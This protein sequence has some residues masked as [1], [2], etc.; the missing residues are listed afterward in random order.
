VTA[1]QMGLLVSYIDI[2]MLVSQWCLVLARCDVLK[3]FHTSSFA[4]DERDCI[5]VKTESQV[6]LGVG[7]GIPD[8]E[9]QQRGSA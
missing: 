7:R 4:R 6:R 2:R 9:V 8:I 3:T 5:L 1:A